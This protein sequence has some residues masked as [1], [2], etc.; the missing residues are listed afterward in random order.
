MNSFETTY[1]AI[2]GLLAAWRMFSRM[3]GGESPP[4]AGGWPFE[5]AIADA[6]VIA[7]NFGLALWAGLML[8]E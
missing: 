7:T 5:S 1:V 3:L 8:F 4:P 6:C 2:S